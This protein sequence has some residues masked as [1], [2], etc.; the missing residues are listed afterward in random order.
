MVYY[1]IVKK[2][3]DSGP[4]KPV[5]RLEAIHIRT[6]KKWTKSSLAKKIF[7]FLLKIK[8]S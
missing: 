7:L 5:E 8:A 4:P 1:V 3:Y 6:F 2:N